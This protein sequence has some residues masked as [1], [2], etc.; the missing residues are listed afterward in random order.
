MPRPSSV[1]LL[2]DNGALLLLRSSERAKP[3]FP[4]IWRCGS[5]RYSPVSMEEFGAE[6]DRMGRR[7]VMAAMLHPDDLAR[8]LSGCTTAG[9]APAIVQ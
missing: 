5:D 3:L 2:L 8:L 9:A 7:E 6:I 1:R 4:M